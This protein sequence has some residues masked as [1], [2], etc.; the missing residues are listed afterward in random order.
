MGF[1]QFGGVSGGSFN[2]DG[3]QLA[4]YGG[5]DD[6]E[7]YNRAIIS[8]GWYDGDSKRLVAVNASPVDPSGSFD[9]DAIAFY[10][11]AGYRFLWGNHSQVTPYIG[12]GASNGEID[13]FTEK[14]P[15][16]TGANLRIRSSD[17]DSLFTVLG[18]RWN[19]AWGNFRP[20]VGLGWEHEYEDSFQTINASF[21]Q[22]K[23]GTQFKVRGTDV[24]EDALLLEVGT[25]YL[26]GSSAELTFG[27]M[28]R[29]YDNYDSQWITGRFTWKFGAAAPVVAAPVAAEPLKIGTD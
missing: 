12:I 11:E 29:W 23:S 18:G 5:F 21:A 16:G 28:G 14:D 1:D 10:N 25:T 15:F 3:G 24:G 7:W 2:Y 6:C 20:Q 19:G 9:A 26:V 22:D 17:G 13:G 8:W 4:V 27:Y